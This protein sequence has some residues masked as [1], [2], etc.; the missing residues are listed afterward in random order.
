[1]PR[2]RTDLLEKEVEHAGHLPH[3]SLLAVALS[4]PELN[5]REVL[6]DRLEEPSCMRSRSS[7]TRC[8]SST[9][10]SRWPRCWA[11]LAPSSACSTP[12]PAWGKVV[13]FRPK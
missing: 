11:C 7:I 12:L 6:S 4:H 3:G 1:L 2:L 10:R 13:Q 9:P 8:G 5:D